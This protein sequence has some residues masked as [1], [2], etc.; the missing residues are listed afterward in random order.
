MYVNG[1]RH[2]A[3]EGMTMHALLAELEI[4]PCAVAVLHGERTYKRG[5]VPDAPLADGDV[6][7]IVTMMQGG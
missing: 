7:E 4:D 5:A 1:A 3:R 6:I 2:P